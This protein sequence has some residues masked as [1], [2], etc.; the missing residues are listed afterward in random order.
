[1][2]IAFG[3]AREKTQLEGQGKANGG[4]N[5]SPEVT[6]RS[7]WTQLVI[8]EIQNHNIREHQHVDARSSHELLQDVSTLAAISAFSNPGMAADANVSRGLRTLLPLS[9]PVNYRAKDGSRRPMTLAAAKAEMT[10]RPVSASYTPPP[11]DFLVNSNTSN[12]MHRNGLSASWSPATA[13]C[14]P[15]AFAPA[16][17][18]PMI[19]RVMK[20]AGDTFFGEESSPATKVAAGKVR[21]QLA[22]ADAAYTSIVDDYEAE[23]N[24]QEIFKF[25]L[26]QTTLE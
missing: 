23:K 3:I 10:K 12:R 14:P 2:K 21:S 26:E 13:T 4:S 20:R 5:P 8:T 17:A 15:L 9:G 6:G 24:S 16:P 18:V 1:M 25:C 7:A 19:K 22:R 11:I